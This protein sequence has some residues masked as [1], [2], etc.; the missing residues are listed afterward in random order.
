MVV[1]FSCLSVI[2]RQL[3]EATTNI[4]QISQCC[5][6]PYDLDFA[7]FELREVNEAATCGLSSTRTIQNQL[8]IYI[9]DH[10]R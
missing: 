9:V 1:I 10:I 4:G 7:S 5:A 8:D 6:I 2:I 3:A